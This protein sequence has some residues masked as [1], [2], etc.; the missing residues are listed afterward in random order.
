MKVA[1]A[2]INCMVGDIVGNAKKI[3]ASAAQAKAQGATLLVT[4]ELSLCGY[5]PEDLLL[6]TDFL[7]ACERTLAQLSQSLLGITVIVGH[8]HQVGDECFNAASVLQDGKILATYHKHELP[9]HSVFDEKRYFSSGYDALVFEHEGVQI[10]VLIC[11]DVWESEPALQAKAAGAEL[12]IALNASPFH[13]EKQSTRLEVL[14][15]RVSETQLPIIYTNM[16]GGQDELVF[17]GASFVL[18]ADAKLTHQLPAFESTLALVEFDG[19]Q[20][21]STVTSITPSLSLEASVYTA[22]KLGLADYVNK[23]GFPGVVLG[24]SGGI[25]SALTLAIAVDALGADKVHAVM[26]PSEFTA[27]IS[28][29]DA[30]EMAEILGVKYNEIAIRLLFDEYLKMLSPLFGDLASDASEENLQARIRG[31]LLMA[32]SN[33]FGSIVVTTGNKSEMAVGYC[34]L[35]GD[36]A[37]GFALLKDVP[38][39]LVYALSNYRNSLSRV[40]PERIITRPPSAELRPNQLDQDSLPPYDVLDGIIQAYVEDDLSSPDIIARGY[41]ATDVKRVISMI[42]RNEYKRRQSPIGVRITHRGFGKDRRHPITV[43]ANFDIHL[44]QLLN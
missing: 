39:T 31:M 33:K 27:D 37:G 4:P 3:I 24:L 1:I 22:L 20:P 29:D 23:N 44:S 2:Q 40:I 17:D 28:V 30:R 11:A 34:T 26:M 32:I 15:Q 5:P 9:N 8:P 21:I 19:T 25:D 13:M 16:V 42:D 14:G 38:K 43:K 6:R 35:Y 12:L 36:M 10:G 7:L 41:S 18:D